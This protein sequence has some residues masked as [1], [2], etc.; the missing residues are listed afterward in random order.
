MA[1]ATTTERA[2]ESAESAPR[3]PARSA[4]L[5]LALMLLSLAVLFALTHLLISPQAE[6]WIACQADYPIVASLLLGLQ[7]AVGKLGPVWGL[8]LLILCWQIG[9][10]QF[11][12]MMT[13]NLLLGGLAAA[14]G[15]AALF[16]MAQRCG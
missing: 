15:L 4:A 12:L 7:L 13:A 16:L 8:G 14:E 5:P 2:P 6:R 3:K 11:G 9:G 1:E 10:R